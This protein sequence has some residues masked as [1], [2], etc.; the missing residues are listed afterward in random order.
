[1]NHDALFQAIRD[2]P[3][4]N[5]VRLV[6]SDWLEEYDDPERAEFIRAQIMLLQLPDDDERYNE[7]LERQAHLWQQRI[8]PWCK[9]RVPGVTFLPGTRGFPELVLASREAF[10]DQAERIWEF[11]PVVRWWMEDRAPLTPDESRRL[12]EAPQLSYLSGFSINGVA[13]GMENLRILLTSPHWERLRELT[14][15]HCS[16]G[17]E[18]AVYLAGSPLLG[19]LTRLNLHGNTIGAAGVTALVNSSLFAQVRHLNLAGSFPSRTANIGNEGTIV[20]ANAPPTEQL[21][22]LDLRANQLNHPGYETLLRS[23]YL[24]AIEHLY[25]GD[26]WGH[27]AS[28]EQRVAPFRA[29]LLARFGKRIHIDHE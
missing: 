7:L 11:C 5:D 3:D 9:E 25:V 26:H 18:A 19:K 14:L 13:L 27:D 22:T 28:E 12:A 23:P 24:D 2:N 8:V 16:L 17:R 6:Y 4:D 20:L 15:S 29:D 21:R 1:M 10:L